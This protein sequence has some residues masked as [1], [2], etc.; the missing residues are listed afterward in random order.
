MS[1]HVAWISFMFLSCCMY[2]FHFPF[3]VYSFPFICLS[4]S[5][6]FALM[7]FHVPFIV[8]WCPFVFLS[9][10][11]YVPACS[12]RFACPWIFFSFRTH[13]QPFSSNSA[14]I[15]LHV[16]FILQSLPVMF[17]SRCIHVLSCF[18]V[19]V[20]LV[21]FCVLSFRIHFQIVAWMLLSFPFIL[22]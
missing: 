9:F 11:I 8:Y 1:F 22:Q 7:S 15:S 5:F 2:S 18:P 19:I 14:V 4:F 13:I 12:F 3:M 20:H 10:C 16:P 17:L 21:P 6:N